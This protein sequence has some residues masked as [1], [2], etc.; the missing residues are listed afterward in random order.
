MAATSFVL[1]PRL[2]GDE[3]VLDFRELMVQFDSRS[4]RPGFCFDTFHH[5]NEHGGDRDDDQYAW[6][7]NTDNRWKAPQQQWNGVNIE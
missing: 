5:T 3:S 7:H 2:V 6:L 4:L 1:A